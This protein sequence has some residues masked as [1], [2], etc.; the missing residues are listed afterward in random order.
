MKLKVKNLF[1]G[2]LKRHRK[3]V[4]WF[5]VALFLFIVAAVSSSDFAI[6][7]FSKTFLFDSIENIP[8]NKVGLVL[9]TSKRLSNGSLNLYFKYRIEAAVLLYKSGRIEF[10]IVSGDNRSMYYNEPIEM[11]KEL[12]ASGVPDSV[13]YLDYAGLRTLDSVIR[14]WKIFGQRKFTVVSQKFQN[15]RA[16]YL[17]RKLGIEA[18]GFNAEDVSAYYGFRTNLREHF[19]RV[20]VFIDLLF[21]TQPRFLGDTVNVSK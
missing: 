16:V 14:C 3:K 15:E 8:V 9:G 19:A 20:K 7:N 21:D 13:I 12:L 2:F 6:K 11:K 4:L 10:I 1:G 18:I 17:A 5:S